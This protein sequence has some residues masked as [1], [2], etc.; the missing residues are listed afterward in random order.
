[1]KELTTPL[2]PENLK[3]LRAG[4]WVSISGRLITARDQ[5]HRRLVELMDRGERLP[6]EFRGAIIYYVGPTPAPPGMACGA[7]GPTT[8]YRM[9]PYTPR[10]LQTGVLALM[11]KG[12]RSTEVKDAL[13]GHG[14]IYLA[15]IGGA[16][17]YLSQKIKTIKLAAFPELGPEAL[18][19]MEVEGF[20][21]IVINDT[22]GNDYYETLNSSYGL[23]QD[24]TPK[25]TKNERSHP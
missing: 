5:T 21:A 4:D 23:K 7:A 12:P 13:K 20:P 18:Y 9:D 6:V 8:S 19:E 16:G 25:K 1:M 10:I 11:G 2:R 3:W 14:A 15:T 22:L 24:R 17:A